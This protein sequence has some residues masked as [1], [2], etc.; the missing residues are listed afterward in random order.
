VHAVLELLLLVTASIL[1]CQVNIE[2]P[3]V[4]YVRGRRRFA[5]ASA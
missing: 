5:M 3:C 2:C 4:V 1:L